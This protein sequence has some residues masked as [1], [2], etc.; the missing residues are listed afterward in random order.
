MESERE[1]DGDQKI[2]ARVSAVGC[3]YAV[4]LLRSETSVSHVLMTK[5]TLIFTSSGAKNFR[6]L[7]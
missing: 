6:I 2:T 3:W 1:S 5:L 4:M 7:K